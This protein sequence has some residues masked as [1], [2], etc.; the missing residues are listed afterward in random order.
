MFLHHS[1]VGRYHKYLQNTVTM[2]EFFGI[3]ITIQLMVRHTI[4]MGGKFEK[5]L[6]FHHKRLALYL[7]EIWIICNICKWAHD[8]NGS[9]PSA[10][11]PKKQEAQLQHLMRL[12]QLI[13][14]CVLHQFPSTELVKFDFIALHITKSW[15]SFQMKISIFLS[16]EYKTHLK[17][18]AIFWRSWLRDLSTD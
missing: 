2:S 17:V 9:L 8:I 5:P 11:E 1:K 6:M 3:L 7:T 12:E 14:I 18:Y 10:G 13:A 16:R 15:N 4:D